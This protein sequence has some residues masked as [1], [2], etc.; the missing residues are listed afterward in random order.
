MSEELSKAVEY[1]DSM[2]FHEIIEKLCS[3]DP[4]L[5]RRW[6]RL[7]AEAAVQFYKNFLFICR[8]YLDDSAHI[9]PSIEIDEVWHHHILDTQRY[10]DDCHQ[11]FG[12]YIHHFPYFGTRG[13]EDFRNLTTAFENFQRLHVAEFGCPVPSIWH[14]TA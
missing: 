12:R 10:S 14:T 2:D 13:N 6:N 9:A 11:I 1:I 8:K 7:E 5:S 4:L 3:E